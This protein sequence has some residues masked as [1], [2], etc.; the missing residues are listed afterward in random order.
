[1]WL[2]WRD[3]EY[4]EYLLHLQE[5]RNV[6]YSFHFL[7]C[8]YKFLR[9]N[10]FL[11]K[12]FLLR[13][14]Y[15]YSAYCVWIT[16]CWKENIKLC[17]KNSMLCYCIENILST[18]RCWNIPLIMMVLLIDYNHYNG[19]ALHHCSSEQVFALLMIFYG[20]E[21]HFTTIDPP[22]EIRIIKCFLLR[23]FVA[24]NFDHRVLYSFLLYT[25]LWLYYRHKKS[26]EKQANG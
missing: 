11:D 21:Y 14:F 3:S 12:F 10:L 22:K 13:R 23:T 16:K 20:V 4:F 18:T 7:N 25:R 1:M 5:S 15:G 24:K 19:V 2:N 26:W 9:C 6:K 8:Y 17:L